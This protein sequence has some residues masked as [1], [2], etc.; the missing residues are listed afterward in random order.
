MYFIIQELSIILTE[1]LT[2]GSVTTELWPVILVRKSFHKKD[3][4]FTI[5]SAP[6]SS[7][8]SLPPAPILG[9][10]AGT[11]SNKTPTSRHNSTYAPIKCL[12]KCFLKRCCFSGS[13]FY[14]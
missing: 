6:F 1:K 5:A 2:C 14:V 9:V 13:A 11:A 10:E 3:N 4:T 7:R 12:L 8:S